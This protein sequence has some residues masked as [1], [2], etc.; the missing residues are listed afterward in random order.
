M[1]AAGHV[2]VD[3]GGAE[4]GAT[5]EFLYD[6]EVRGCRTAEATLVLR[7]RIAGEFGAFAVA[8]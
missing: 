4:P 2:G 3:L 6:S 7:V 5:E 8:S 1:Q